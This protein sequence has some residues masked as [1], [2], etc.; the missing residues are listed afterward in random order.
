[1]RHVKFPIALRRDRSPDG[2]T[3]WHLN[4]Q[5]GQTIWPFV[6]YI[7]DCTD[8]QELN[9]KTVDNRAHSLA[10]WFR[11]LAEN[12]IGMWQ[13]TD[14]A[15]KDFRK[16][17][18]ERESPNRSGDPQARRRTINQDLRNI[19]QYYAWLQQDPCHG[20]GRRLLGA[21]LCQIT[22]TLIEDPSKRSGSRK[23]YPA[24]FRHAGERSKH[25]LGFVPGESHRAALSEYFY[26]TFSLEVARR[27]CQMFELAWCVGWRRGS[28]L[29]LTTA[30]FETA[31]LS[32]GEGIKITP[33]RQKFGYTNSF[34][35][36]YR[37]AI[38]VLDFID[39]ERTAC[40][41]RTGSTYQELFLSDRTGRPLTPGAVSG[42]FNKA[43]N[44][45]GWPKGASLHA[46]RRG[47][48]NAYLER[49][50]DA[51]LELGMDTGGETIAM[52][53]AQALGQES[54]SSQA[55]Y[56]RDAQRRI[57]G[58]TS[59]RDKEEHARL[60]DENARLRKD[61]ASLSKMVEDGKVRRR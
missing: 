44:A 45:L 60:A 35:V 48:T 16:W 18:M 37:T 32:Q 54:L 28:V 20:A 38:Q 4:D 49:E 56:V 42:I 19:Y 3:Y 36:P 17:L 39:S 27:N 52:S 29:S 43:R 1:M 26:D 53:L 12:H 61:V 11:F 40:V 47:F 10:Q 13:A 55:A 5:D 31:R 21:G 9:A 15:L 59:F 57:R 14:Q 34:D 24:T 51:R 30:D 22:S 2:R 46:W 8:L 6:D 7:I 33:A 25:R 41:A 58:S 50:L 23:R